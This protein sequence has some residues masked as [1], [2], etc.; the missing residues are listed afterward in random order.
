MELRYLGV[1][2]DELWRRLEARNI[3]SP[4]GAVPI[5]RAQLEHWAT[6]F[7][8]PDSAEIDLFDD[9]LPTHPNL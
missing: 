8:V 9:P 2:L 1:S 5:T 4:S 6:L 3:D 7:E